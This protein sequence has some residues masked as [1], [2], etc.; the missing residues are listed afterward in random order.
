MD[1]FFYDGVCV[2]YDCW[3]YEEP[4]RATEDEN[5][6]GYISSTVDVGWLFGMDC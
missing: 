4:V 5:Y 3:S 6:E 1:S 2:C